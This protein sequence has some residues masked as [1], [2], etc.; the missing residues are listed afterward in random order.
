M[1]NGFTFPIGE[2]DAQSVRK[3]VQEVLEKSI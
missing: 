2:N 1:G 3:F